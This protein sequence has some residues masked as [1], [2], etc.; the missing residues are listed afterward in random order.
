[1]S[2]RAEVRERRQRARR[3]QLVGYVGVV[4]VGALFVAAMILYPKLAP[5]GEITSITPV[6]RPQADGTAMG[7]PN[8][9][10]LI[11]LYED[12]QCPACQV[13]TLQTEPL[14]VENY[15]LTGKARVVFRHFPFIEPA[16]G[17]E[18]TQAAN[19][20]MCAAEQGRFWD[21]HDMLYT[22]Q[23]GENLGA[24]AN[25]RL[26]AFAESL[27]LDMQA[28][29]TCFDDDAYRDQIDSDEQSGLQ[30]G[31]NSTPT[32]VVNGT[33]VEGDNP[34]LV[35]SYEIISQAIDAAIGS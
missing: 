4:G 12:F 9:P 22:N 21:Y 1:M 10:V 13:F 5:V 19:A 17:G 25:R 14:L 15:V 34:R 11:E 26:V 18:S 6:A 24:F 20:S 2:K 28:F 32:I 33:I 31:V 27:G 8:A 30:L 3:R 29:N 7:D 16:P 35:P 23:S